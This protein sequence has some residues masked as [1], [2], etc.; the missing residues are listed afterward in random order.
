MKDILDGIR[1]V[2]MSGYSEM[3]TNIGTLSVLK[4]L[5]V[6]LKSYQEMFKVQIIVFLCSI[7]YAVTRIV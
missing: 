5:K 3:E 2:N 7:S 6:D 1:W 4:M